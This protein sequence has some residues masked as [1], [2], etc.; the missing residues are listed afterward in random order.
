MIRT[1]L[2]SLDSRV[3]FFSLTETKNNRNEYRTKP[4]WRQENSCVFSFLVS[5]PTR[6][7]AALEEYN[8][9]V[10]PGF[11]YNDIFY[12]DFYLDDFKRHATEQELKPNANK[13]QERRQKT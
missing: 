2:S 12:L 7:H 9:L 8:A 6:L 13:K 4:C 1:A 3:S 11:A 10:S 5:S